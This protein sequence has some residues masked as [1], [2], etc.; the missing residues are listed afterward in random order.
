MKLLRLV[1][2][3]LHLG[4]GI[5]P[6]EPNVFEDFHYDDELAELLAHHDREVGE[7]GE[8]ELI[9]NGDIFDLLKV[10]IG[11]VFPTEITDALATEKLRQCLDGHPRVINALKA[12]VAKPHR[13]I[14]FIPGNHDLDMWFPGPQEL[15]RRY[16]APGP[17]GE[18]VRFV[19]SSDTYYLPEGI[20]IRHGH[21]LERIHRVDYDRMTKKRRDGTEILDLPWGTLWI[22]EVMNPAKEQRS[23]VDRI[24]P[25]SR[26]LLAAL[27]FDTRFVL[28]FLWRS[29]VYWLRWRIFNLGAWRERLSSFSKLVRE[30]IFT[31]GGGFDEAAVR[32]LRKMR[33]VS[34]LIVGHSHGPRFRQLP[35][36]K[37]LVNT[38]TWMRMINLDIRHLGQDSGLT[39]CHILYGDDG[40]PTVGLRRWLGAPRPY[41]LIHYAD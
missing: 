27:L 33:G 31:L 23:Y 30:E 4:T 24:Q 26:F 32:A 11:G 37:I 16:V 21:Q 9:L 38:G 36:G 3:D 22:L 19:T 39:Y 14:V 13:R 17:A 10:K 15:F 35:G 7:D 34:Y 28:G 6:G 40:R 29:S 20:Q 41:Q 8:I 1:L 12:F 2:S 5:R 18:R 25:L